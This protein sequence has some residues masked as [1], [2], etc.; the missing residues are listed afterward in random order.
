[1]TK[2]FETDWLI[3]DVEHLYV[4]F[5]LHAAEDVLGCKFDEYDDSQ[6]ERL[7]T[8]II[9][10][11]GPKWI[12]LDEVEF[13]H[14]THIVTGGIRFPGPVAFQIK[15]AVWLEHLLDKILTR[16]DRRAGFTG[17]DFSATT[18]MLGP[19]EW[20]IQDDENGHHAVFE[21][22]GEDDIHA[23]KEPE[24]RIIPNSDLLT[25]LTRGG[26]VSELIDW[27]CVTCGL[28]SDQTCECN[29]E[30]TDI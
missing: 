29:T 25:W 17:A 24:I 27:S 4:Y 1:M 19:K 9:E 21:R 12:T 20:F 15:S 28:D 30:N 8:N 11:D 6:I 13:E 18:W 16:A 23:G 2:L 14:H 10:N 3:E 5:T 26:Q 22:L 7:K